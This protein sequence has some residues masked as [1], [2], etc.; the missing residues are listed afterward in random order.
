ML[1]DPL[2]VCYRQRQ[3][4]CVKDSCWNT[5][6]ALRL[7]SLLCD[8]RNYRTLS[9]SLQDFLHSAHAK[10]GRFQRE[11]EEEDAAGG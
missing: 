6:H 4:S 2:P 1:R 5:V 11:E 3:Y 7:T 9:G 10:W 8:N